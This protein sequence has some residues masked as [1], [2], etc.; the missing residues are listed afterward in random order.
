MSQDK[1]HENTKINFVSVFLALFSTVTYFLV[2]VGMLYG[3]FCFILMDS[4]T[5]IHCASGLLGISFLGMFI[6][7]AFKIQ[8][9]LIKK[10]EKV[11][12]Q[13]KSENSSE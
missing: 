1:N 7:L 5:A 9:H 11:L 8:K 10:R 13:A 12:V 3:Y 4:D 6:A 2:L